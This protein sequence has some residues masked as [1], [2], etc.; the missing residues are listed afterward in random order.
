[1]TGDEVTPEDPEAPNGPNGPGGSVSKAQAASDWAIYKRLLR[2]VLPMWPL[3]LIALVGFAIGSATE[4]YFA[5]MFGDVV[6]ELSNPVRN[7]WLYY[8]IAVAIV[9]VIRA[10]GEFSGEYFLARVSFRVVHTLRTE[11]FDQ[12]LVMPS[13]VFDHSARG[14]LVSRITFN[15]A[16]VRDTATDALKIVIQ[17]G[18]KVLIMVGAMLLA[19]WQLTL[20]FLSIAPLVGVVVAYA[21]RR[22]RRI[23]RRI[24]NSMGDVTHVASEMVNGYRV[25]R[26]FGGEEYERGRFF[27]SSNYNRRQQLKM[28]TTKAWSTQLIQVIV[29]LS[30]AVLIG[31][32]FRPELAGSMGPGD[33]VYFVGLA[34]LLARPIRRLSEVNARL[35]RGLAAAEDIFGQLDQEPEADAGAQPIERAQG[36]IEFQN[37]SF[38]YVGGDGPV[39]HEIN[40]SIA[41][42]Q[43]IALVGRSGSGKSTLASLLPRF[44]DVSAGQILMDGRPLNDY[45]MT[46]LRRQIALVTQDVVLFN[47]TLERNIAYGALVDRSPEEVRNAIVRAH[48]DVFIDQLPDGLDTIVGDNGLLL[49]GGQRQ[50][51]AIARALLKDAPVLILDEAT[52]A[53]DTTSER[54]IQAALE[55]VMRGRTTLVIAH[56]LS[57]IEKADLIVVL[58]GGRIVEQGTHAQLLSLGGM[59]SSLYQSQFT[60]PDASVGD[61][62]PTRDGIRPKSRVTR[63]YVEATFNPLLNAWYSN[64]FWPRLLLPLAKLFE[65]INR[66]RRY[67]YLTGTLSRWRAPVPV[68]I[69]GNIN[70]D[71]TGKSPLVIW[72]AAWL[73]AR[74]WHPG[75][76][77]QVAGAKASQHPLTVTDQTTPQ[78]AGDTAPMLAARTGCP[79]VVGPDRIAASQ[80]LLTDHDVDLLIHADGLQDHALA[81]DVEIAVVDGQRGIGNGLCLPAGPLRE[82]YAR[83][84]DF[85]LVVGAGALTGLVEGESLMTIKGTALVHLQNSNRL[86]AADLGPRVHAVTAI[87]NPR[88]FSR[89]LEEFGVEPTLHTFP[90][91]Y[92]IRAD[93]LLFDDDLPVVIT[94][95]D[96]I[97]VRALDPDTLPRQCYYLEIEA[98]L[99][100]RGRTALSA[101]LHDHGLAVPVAPVA[102]AAPPG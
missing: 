29:A 74:G 1:M 42:G 6:D 30:L 45:K 8:P 98:Q 60:E 7:N 43:T 81:R 32:L 94:E 96:A 72:L 67:R 90:R 55:E 54:Y 20:I 47:D 85:D 44:Y 59:Y 40:L 58:D 4:A 77:S 71:G 22:F 97:R 73:R 66:R 9:A 2:Y 50:R 56:R 14:H 75:I 39:L 70:V 27:E 37:V 25:V 49:S 92:V 5:R 34:G 53:L 88:R 24:Q 100:E 61:A 46:D 51:V 19:S 36:R 87:E 95:R 86:D 99:D 15:V 13:A 28:T 33:V 84:N 93:D 79:V 11:L 26:T 102:A 65:A 68:I 82:P 17:D 52:S 89:T 10:L 64:R 57:T 3:F 91:N 80:A 35:Q 83:L 101:C 63:H 78:Q 69:V 76:I 21:S 12:L 38:G 18:S 62:T 31:M 48:A 23:S 41:P 16:Q